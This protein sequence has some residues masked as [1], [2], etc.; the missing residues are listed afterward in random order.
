[1]VV[2]LSAYIGTDTP[3]KLAV[4]QTAKD[5]VGGQVNTS[6]AFVDF[7]A[8]TKIELVVKNQETGVILATVDSVDE[9]AIFAVED[10]YE[11][12]LR[13]GHI[14]G[15]V[16]GEIYELRLLGYNASDADDGEVLADWSSD[17]ETDTIVATA[18]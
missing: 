2:S 3:A 6:T 12:V 9:A 7:S 8:Y 18:R 1:M 17:P 13:L 16:A 10:S 15:L 4:K 14:A 5:V 11:L